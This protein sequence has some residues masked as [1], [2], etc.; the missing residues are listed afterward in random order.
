MKGM[1]IGAQKGPRNAASRRRWTEILSHLGVAFTGVN[2]LEDDA[3]RQGVK[4]F[5]N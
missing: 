4:K 1:S 2:V 3:I 5:S